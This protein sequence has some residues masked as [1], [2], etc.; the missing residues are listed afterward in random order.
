M[1]VA[2]TGVV[3]LNLTGCFDFLSPGNTT[4]NGTDATDGDDGD[5]RDGDGPGDTSDDAAADDD[6]GTAPAART[7]V[8]S[9]RCGQ[10][11]PG[12]YAMFVNSGHPYKLNEIV[13]DGVPTYPFSTIDGALELISDDDVSPLAVDEAPD[14]GVGT[15]NTLGT[16]GSYRDIS[17]V[18]GGYGWKARWIDKDGYIVT[19]SSVQFNLE[20]E[21]FASYHDN[22]TD[23]V[24]NCGNCH[25]T[26]W[27]RYTSE[28]GDD[29]NLNRQNDLPGMEGTFAFGGVHCEACHGA[30]SDHVAGPNDDNITKIASARTT[31]QFLAEDMAYGAPAACGDC[32][33]RHA[34]KDYPT[35]VGGVGLIQTSGG[36]IR[37]HE[38]HDEMQ[39]IN[40][41]DESAGATGPHASLTCI[42][43]HNPHTST[44]YQAIS[45]DPPGMDTDCTQ[46]H[47]ADEYEIAGGGM[48]GFDCV[49]CHMPK[50][51]KSAIAHDAVGTGP[52]TGD[53]RTHIFRI[54]LSAASQVT[55]DGSFAYPWVTGDFACK[56]CHNGETEFDIEFPSSMT[57][58]N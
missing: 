46:C 27:R 12:I 25:T 22:E 54:D 34:E 29:R 20:T 17:F 28:A 56:T 19:G 37:H 5:D 36:L 55:E 8:G 2:F 53:I 52:S 38:Q 58:H 30:G 35:Y 13:S 16:P 45:G 42:T 33:T 32:H 50:L 6:G 24:Y 31:E 26:G 49:T 47:S 15:D 51:V 14:P 10:C 1:T 23:K 40:P 41:D 57:I 18:I 44:R 9:E 3:A 7:Y 48:A 21:G 11:H 39:G 43:C 4:N